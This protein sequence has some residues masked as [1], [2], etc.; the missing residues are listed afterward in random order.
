MQPSRRAPENDLFDRGCDLV[1]AASA[2]RRLAA[3]P[4]SAR[5][6]PAVL[7]CIETS[8]HELAAAAAE[9]ESAE[10][11]ASTSEPWLGA[12]DKRRRRGLA[13]LRMALAD[14]ATASQAAR[15]LTARVLERIHVD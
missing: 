14:A 13:N 3:D 5:A 10:P 7:G 6:I 8:L 4:E 2:I 9:L 1:E 12:A 11:V 15:G